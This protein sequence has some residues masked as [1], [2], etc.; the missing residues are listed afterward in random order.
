MFADQQGTI[1]DG[2][3]AD[4]GDLVMSISF[5]QGQ[6]F[7]TPI[8]ISDGDSHN[9]DRNTNSNDIVVTYS[10]NGQ[11][12]VTVYTDLLKDIQIVEPI[13]A[14][15]TCSGTSFD[16]DFNLTGQFGPSTLFTA[17]LSDETGSFANST[18]VGQV[19]TNTNKWIK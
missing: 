3:K 19:V 9:I 14:I 8:I 4:S 17:V 15:E 5:D 16:L 7:E 11:V 1:I 18:N 13:P 10:K 12:F 2:Y 6:N